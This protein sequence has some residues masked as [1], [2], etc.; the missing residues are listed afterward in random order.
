M[1]PGWGEKKE[2][3]EQ[4][5][6]F[7]DEYHRTMGIHH[8]YAD[9][10]FIDVLKRSIIPTTRTE[11]DL[12]KMDLESKVV[13]P[14]IAVYYKPTGIDDYPQVQVFFSKC[15]GRDADLFL[16][17]VRTVVSS[18]AV[19]VVGTTLEGLK[20]I[21]AF[22]STKTIQE[23]DGLTSPI[24]DMSLIGDLVRGEDSLRS[25]PHAHG[26]PTDSRD[27]RRDRGR[28]WLKSYGFYASVMLCFGAVVVIAL[29]FVNT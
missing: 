8:T 5:K 29:V 26:Q 7:L 6:S 27:R 19:F 24:S 16:R 11:V 4:G 22:D 23:R 17:F 28:S 20:S 15:I 9:S 14:G 18:P 21:V 2:K 13:S 10:F 3:P 25:L 12:K 1:R